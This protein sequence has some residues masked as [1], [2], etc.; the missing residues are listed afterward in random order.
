MLRIISILFVFVWV[1]ASAVLPE[2]FAD[3]RRGPVTPVPAPDPALWREFGFD[4]AERADYTS[5]ATGQT[6]T[7]TAFRFADATGAFAAFQW[8]RPVDA[9]S[10]ITSARTRSGSLI[11]QYNFLLQMEGKKPHPSDLQQLYTQLPN[12]VRASLPILHEYLPRRGRVPNSERYVLGPAGLGAAE[13]RI[14]AE[15]ASFGKG[16]EAQL[17]RYRLQGREI[18]LAI[19][20]YPTPQIAMER[21]RA[22]EKLS[23]ALVRRTG[24]MV[25]VVPDAA[26]FEPAAKLLSEVNY[27]AS[28][29]WNEPAPKDTVQ[30]AAE[31]I[32]AIALLAVGLIV[33]SVLL[34]TVFG[35]SKIL[36]RKFG[37][38]TAEEEFTSLHLGEK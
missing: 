11:Q 29:T 18:Q 34:G 36:L 28:L 32:L 24:P 33:L 3:Y 19:L 23:G 8:Q 1:A 27:S 30:D 12:T 35:G 6:F 14:S 9:E 17:A 7:L 31:M 26:G 21:T 13:P 5:A 15:L 4:A 22:F 38:K 37:I 16:A 10:G 20:A 25:L 2:A